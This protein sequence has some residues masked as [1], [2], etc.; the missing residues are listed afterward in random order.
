MVT[1]SDRARGKQAV[2]DNTHNDKNKVRISDFVEVFIQLNGYVDL[3]DAAQDLLGQFLNRGLAPGTCR[4]YLRHAADAFGGVGP[5]F[6]Q[7]LSAATILQAEADSKNSCRS[8]RGR[9]Q[10]AD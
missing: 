10:G 3:E 4:N 9:V 6:K 7:A 1:P 8:Y 5:K 2:D